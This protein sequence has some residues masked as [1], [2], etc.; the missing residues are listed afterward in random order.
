MSNSVKVREIECASAIG[1]CNFPG[2]GWAINPYV[3][4]RHNCAYCYARFIRRF[5]GHHEPWGSFVDARLNIADV[6]EKQLRSKKY[7]AGRIYIGTVT[8]PYQPAEEKYRLTR[9]VLETLLHHPNPISILTKSDLVLRDLDLLK[10]FRKIDVNFTINAFDE[11]WKKLV[12]PH[13]PSIR[14]RL[15]AIRKLTQNNIPVFVMMG[16]Y[17]PYFTQPEKMYPEFKKLGV[18]EIFTESFNT[19]GGNW[20]GVE[21]VLKKHYPPL[22]DGMREI[23]FNKQKFFEFY[24]AAEKTL[25]QLEA[26]YQLPTTIYFGLGHAGKFERQENRL[27]ALEFDRTIGLKRVSLEDHKR[28]T[29]PTC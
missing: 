14:Q 13:S 3:G 8:D 16:P 21:A 22:I 12:E 2:G 9:A 24:A 17:W 6:L 29:T 4:C 18:K 5:T 7:H 10:H 11:G 15:G 26:K 20:T 28:N 23:F 1:Q 27:D 19:T 25:R